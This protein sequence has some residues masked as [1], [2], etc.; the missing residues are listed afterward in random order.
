MKQLLIALMLICCTE[1]AYSQVKFNYGIKGGFN[2]STYSYDPDDAQLRLGQWGALC[3]LTF[4][5][6][7]M[8]VQPEII[9]SRQG[10]RSLDLL[11][12]KHSKPEWETTTNK[13]FDEVF[14]VKITTQYVQM[15]I[16]VKYYIPKMMGIN[17]QAGPQVG[18]M[19][20]YEISPI[21]EY[22]WMAS[23]EMGAP[24]STRN[25]HRSMNYW[26]VA[27]NVGAGFDSESGIGVDFRCGLGLTKVF[28]DGTQY[29]S[30]NTRDRVWSLA[31]SYT[32]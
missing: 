1:A 28:E 8:A 11:R 18:Y 21:N 32:F 16:M 22:G 15:P 27:L 20:D 4:L 9:Y 2:I 24:L 10:S 13:W 31:F 30:S 14:K 5:N 7:S 29:A 6:G 25:I 23:A 12:I 19:F 26:N 17:V 3:R